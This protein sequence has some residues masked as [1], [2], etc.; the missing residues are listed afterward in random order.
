MNGG[1]RD[2]EREKQGIGE[3]LEGLVQCM[4]CVLFMRG[5]NG[6]GK[7]GKEGGEVFCPERGSSFQV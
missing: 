7:G 6:G 2:I 3:F 1:G 4:V 5:R